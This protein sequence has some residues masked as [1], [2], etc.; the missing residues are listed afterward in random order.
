MDKNQIIEALRTIKRNLK[1]KY[2]IDEIFIFGSYVKGTATPNSDI[3]IA[4][5]VNDKSF[6]TWANY[7][8]AKDDF[9]NLLKKDIDV[10]YI[11]PISVNPII[12]DEIEKDSIKIE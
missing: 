11:D 1:E 6:L 7:L 8:S 9:N 3:D 2:G 12:L 10:V 4:V 5:K